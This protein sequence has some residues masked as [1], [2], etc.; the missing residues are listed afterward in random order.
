VENSNLILTAR[1]DGLLIGV[2]RCIT[3]FAYCCY[4]SDL[5]VDVAYQGQKIGQRLLKAT[6]AMLHPQA[7]LLLVSAPGAVSFYEHIGMTRHDRCFAVL[8]SETNSIQGV[9]GNGREHDHENQ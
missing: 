1:K 8:P 4:C 7:V 6:K 9:N 2:A 5:A 3:D